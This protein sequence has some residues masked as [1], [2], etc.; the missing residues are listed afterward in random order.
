MIFNF[1]SNFDL[2]MYADMSNDKSLH[3]LNDC[4]S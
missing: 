1:F 4:K 3:H 2:S